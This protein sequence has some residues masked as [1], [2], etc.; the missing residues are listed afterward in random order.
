MRWLTPNRTTGSPTAQ[1]STVG[2]EMPIKVGISPCRA[3]GF[4]TTASG[5]RAGMKTKPR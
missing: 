1:S 2:F 3:V 4:R 5:C